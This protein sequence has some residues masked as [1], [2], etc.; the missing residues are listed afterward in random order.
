MQIKVRAINL[1]ILLEC[2]CCFLF[3]GML[4]YLAGSGKYLSYITP[5]MKPYLYFSA[6]IMGIWALFGIRHLFRPQHRVR[7]IHC[8]ILAVPML[9]ILLP[10]APLGVSDVTKNYTGGN[11]LSDFSGKAQTQNISDSAKTARSETQS[12]EIKDNGSNTL[13]GL[14]A[15][16]KK[17]TVSN[18]DFSTWLAEFDFNGKQYE[19]YTVVMTGFVLKN[20][21]VPKD[22]EFVISRLAMVCCIADL[23][24]TGVRC[25]YENASEL[26]N[27]EWITAEGTFS[28]REYQQGNIMREEPIITVTGITP[29]EP[30]EEYVYPFV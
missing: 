18:E 25:I 12:S 20:S 7:F 10:H 19:G 27:E 9:L 30:V 1:Q 4:I 8:L 26:E 5:R 24:P 21:E 17:I 2:L 6:I 29:A 13:P 11:T 22:D 16:N 23:S 3:S 28:I 14:D 15:E